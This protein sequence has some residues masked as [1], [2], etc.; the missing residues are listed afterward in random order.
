M[1]PFVADP[2]WGW[3][4]VFYFFLGG[5]A[6]GCYF[7]ATLVELLGKEEDRPLA[8][9]GYRLA[10]PLLLVCGVLLILDLN[11][12]ER[13]WHMVL[14]SEL[15]DQA[16][17]EG[18]PWGGWGT[19]VQAAMLKWWSPMSIGAQALGI[20]GLCSFLSFLGSVWPHGRL[21]RFLDRKVPGLILKVLG[22]LVG[23][24]IASYTGVLLT[25][26]NQPLWSQTDWIAPLFLTSAASTGIAVLLLLGRNLALET[27]ERLERADLWAL[28]LELFVFLIFL[29]SLGGVLPLALMTWQGLLLVLGTLLIGLLMPLALHL[30]WKT[31]QGARVTAAALCAL[32]GGFL[33]RFAIVWVAPAL[34]HRFPD[35]TPRDIEAPLWPS[36]VGIG[37]VTGTF[38]LAILI[39]C[40]LARQRQFSRG[41]TMLA[42]LLSVMVSAG[43]SL[44]ALTPAS[45]HPVLD[46]LHW[47]GLSPEEQRER[48]GGPGA[49]VSNRPVRPFLRSKITTGGQP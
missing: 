5:L 9:L 10:F 12:P 1:N 42:G 38:V 44:Y 46:P 2:D 29:A 25:A 45:A 28:C 23:F 20:F 33:L 31:G 34:L 8:R 36:A 22:S 14:Q 41:Q 17:E 3:W 35:V 11:R 7:V 24:F 39:P 40:V 4:I 37:L 49:S 13:F 43:V 26:T 19:I 21:A 6:A 15:V 48:G 27:R 32:V 16:L 30:A 47:I 18:W